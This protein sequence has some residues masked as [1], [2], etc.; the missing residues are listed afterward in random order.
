MKQNTLKVVRTEQRSEEMSELIGR[1]DWKKPQLHPPHFQD[2]SVRPVAFGVLGKLL[3][4][5]SKKP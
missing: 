5:L 4:K 3:K 2:A 1:S